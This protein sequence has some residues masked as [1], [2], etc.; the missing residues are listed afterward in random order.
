[1]SDTGKSTPT[2]LIHNRSGGRLQPTVN[3]PIERG[4]TL[5]M[6]NTDALYG[7]GKTYGRMGLS[8]HRELEAALCELENAEAARLTSCGVSACAL[9]ISSVVKAGDHVLFLDNVYG[10]TRRFCERRLSRM[11]VSQSRVSPRITSE[12]LKDSIQ[13]NTRLLV[14]ETPGSLTFELCDTLALIEVCKSNNVLTVLDNTWG[15]GLYHK[16][17]DI[18]VDISVQALTKYPVGH[19]DAFGGAVL[20]NDPKLSTLVANTAEDWGISIG[21]DDAYLT[22]RGIRTLPARLA[23]HEKAAA[24][25]ADWL[26]EQPEVQS[27]LHPARSDH[28][29]HHIWQR[30]FTGSCGLFA[31]YLNAQSQAQTEAFLDALTLFGQG[32]SWGGYESLLIACDPQLN[33]RTS[34]WAN[35]GP[36]ALM[37]IHIGLED[38]SDLMDDV[39]AGFNAMK[40]YE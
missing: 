23:A 30:D 40:G 21:P 12:E 29:D 17:L 27:V 35:P 28:P 5:L 7:E 34:P 38:I 16:P 36:G 15:C 20:T 39:Q 3:P 24:K 13:D 32:F 26:A 31:F 25:I 37:R 6:D 10:P 33:R 22:L 11:G 4:S 14:L 8:V 18:G 19:A 2:K 9:A 1:M